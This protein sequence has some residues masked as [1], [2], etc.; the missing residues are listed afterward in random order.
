M[1]LSL[2]SKFFSQ[3]FKF[4]LK[5]WSLPPKFLFA[6]LQNLYSLFFEISIYLILYVSFCWGDSHSRVSCELEKLRHKALYLYLALYAVH[7]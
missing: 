6:F 4:S 3:F 7:I 2:F 5:N 1:L